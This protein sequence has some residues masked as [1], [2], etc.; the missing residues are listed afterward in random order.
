MKYIYPKSFSWIVYGATAALVVTMVAATLNY[1][2]SEY[3][4]NKYQE[5]Q[6]E[7]ISNYEKLKNLQLLLSNSDF[8]NTLLI[9]DYFKL[10]SLF[11]SE[12]ILSSDLNNQLTL[13]R[14]K[15]QQLVNQ[16]SDLVQQ[17]ND[18]QNRVFDLMKELQQSKDQLKEVV[19]AG[20]LLQREF[21]AMK[22]NENKGIFSVEFLASYKLFD[23]SSTPVDITKK[24]QHSPTKKIK[25]TD[26]INISLKTVQDL[27]FNFGSKTIYVRIADP[28]GNILPFMKDELDM[29]VFQGEEILFSDKMDIEFSSSNLPVSVQYHPVTVLH[30]G[31]YWV[32][33]FCDGIRIGEASFDLF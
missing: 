25:H 27:D 26:F 4:Q 12:K 1:R 28:Q 16:N 10:D 31:T 21:H 30:P 18:Y 8:E 24:G 33:V 20:N 9:S 7:E 17:L 29:F 14:A 32:Y 6:A 15:Y 22:M 19:E 2:K 3:W 13:A 11:L 5:K 23:V